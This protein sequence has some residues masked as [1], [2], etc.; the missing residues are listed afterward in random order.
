MRWR[1][2]RLPMLAADI[3]WPFAVFSTV[4][5]AV[6]ASLTTLIGVFLANRNSRQTRE[7]ESAER[8]KERA[9]ENRKEQPQERKELYVN[10]VR[11]ARELLGLGE[12]DDAAQVVN[13][14]E[15]TRTSAEVLGGPQVKTAA[16]K[17]DLV[18]NWQVQNEDRRTSIPPEPDDDYSAEHERE[19]TT[20]ETH[21]QNLIKACSDDLVS[22]TV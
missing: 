7:H 15:A 17:I 10:L 9:H 6:V 18:Y 22:L 19:R 8:D 20:S 1:R 2:Y 13:S 21:V 5:A 14:W 3:P 16:R 4:F 11:R 12:S